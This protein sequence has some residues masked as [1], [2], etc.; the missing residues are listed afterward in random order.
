MDS[1][2]DGIILGAGHNGMIL[3]AYLGKAGMR[4]LTIERKAV[5]GGGLS[6]LEDPRHPG[7]LHNTHAFFQR[8]ITAMP[9]YADLELERH[10][11]RYIEPELNVALITQDDGV[12]AWWTDIERTVKSF[13]QF[14]R[15]DAETLR[16]W[17]HEFV[18]IVQNILTPEAKAPPLPPAERRR[19]LERSAAG[20][21]LI[22]VSALSPL[23]FVKQEFE[24]PTVQAG[25]LFFNGLR[26]V[27]L[28]VR[29]FGHHIAALLASPAKAQMSRGGTAALARA[30]EGAV[31]KS[32]GEFRLLTEP[33]RIVVEGGRAVGIETADGE[34][35][36]ARHF[37]ASSLNPHQTFLELL[38]E[39][40]VPLEIRDRVQAFQYNLLAPLFA[41]H[42]NLRE[43]PRYTAAAKFPELAK[44]FMVIMGLDASDQFN[45]IVRHHESG[46][47]PPPVMWGACPTLF[48]PSQAPAGQHTA[49][50]WEKLP[51]HLKAGWSGGGEA[52]GRDMLALWRKHAP[53]LAD[54][55]LDQFTRTPL[56]T[57]RSLPNM[58]EG[59][60]LVGAFTNGQIGHHRPFPGAGAYR[61]H[62]PGLYL[63]GS[64]SH[65]GGNITGL[66]G[67]NAAQVLLDDLGIKSGWAPRPIA[68]QLSALSDR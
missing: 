59:D 45:D 40:L 44:A 1:T 35:I 68:D 9:W 6:T 54:A 61:A 66:P 20:R 46:T 50:M 60:L 58:R 36:R 47:I 4:V 39:T 55:V 12:L 28:R 25:L 56:D 30:L 22:E 24:H 10:G 49:F 33:K 7:F 32:G 23:E 17:Q 67:Y 38:D 5:T 13:E 53:N 57:E 65:P 64:S 31:R 43:P 37:I 29:G 3:Q 15:K 63:C 41:L 51:Y 48:D 52:H 2:Y 14:S 21:R 16:R 19:L 11:A 42:L 18:P 8:A 27:D 34:T 26:E 62:L